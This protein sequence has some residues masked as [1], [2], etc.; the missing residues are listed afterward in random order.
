VAAGSFRGAKESDIE[1]LLAFMQALYQEDGSTPFIRPAVHQALR[2]LLD[3]PDRGRVWLIERDGESAGYLVVTWGFSLEFHGRD[4]FIDELYVAPAHRGRGLGRQAV[5][6]AEAACR[7]NGVA[8]LHLEVET[9]NERAH[10]LYRGRGFA[11][12]GLRLMTKRIALSLLV[13]VLAL[14]GPA[15]AD[16]QSAPDSAARRELVR[17]LA[18][19]RD[20]FAKSDAATL[21]RLLADDYV[22]TNGGSGQVLGREAWLGYVRVRRA[23]LDDGSL[24]VEEYVVSPP[25]IRFRAAAAVV[26]QQVTTAGIRKGE[27]FRSRVQVT[28]VWVREGGR[29][30]RA[31]FHDSPLDAP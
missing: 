4:A 27:P 26:L 11:E 31:A 17:A 10:A 28:Q 15:R 20:A 12:R 30:R 9:G 16:L 21:A 5:G 22:H 23:E 19:F 3:D 1:Q 14:T 7:A 25:D 29:W 24:R 2:E 6:H 18:E 8:A 13:L